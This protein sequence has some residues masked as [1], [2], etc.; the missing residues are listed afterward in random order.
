MATDSSL[1]MGKGCRQLTMRGVMDQRQEAINLSGMGESVRGQDSPDGVSD[2]VPPDLPALARQVRVLEHRV[3][4]LEE[5]LE[6]TPRFF[7]ASSRSRPTPVR[8]SRDGTAKA[9]PALGEALL[10]IAG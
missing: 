1:S 7:Q 6:G 8:P 3:H 4:A 5:R 9:A 2:A 10:A